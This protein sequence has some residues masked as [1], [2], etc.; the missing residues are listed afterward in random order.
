MAVEGGHDD[1]RNSDD[2]RRGYLVGGFADYSRVVPCISFKIRTGAWKG[3]IKG[4][5]EYEDKV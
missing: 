3:T 5:D 1:I 4:E 2:S